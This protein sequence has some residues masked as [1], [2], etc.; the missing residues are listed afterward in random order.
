MSQQETKPIG[1][2]SVDRVDKFLIVIGFTD[3]SSASFT[4]D[5][6]LALRPVRPEIDSPSD[7]M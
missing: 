6:L 5:E 1:I 2:A 4:V 7:S 3:G